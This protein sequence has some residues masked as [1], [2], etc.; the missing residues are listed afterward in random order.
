[1]KRF[2]LIMSV[3]LMAF[4]STAEAKED[5]KD[6]ITIVIN[7]TNIPDKP[8]R[9]P[10]RH[11]ISA[12]YDTLENAIYMESSMS[13]EVEVYITSNNEVLHYSPTINTVFYLPSNNGTYM[14]GLYSKSW[15]AYG[16]LEL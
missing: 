3:L 9:M 7:K 12:W 15:S 8:H 2:A 4:C 10:L 14:I 13:D 16:I 1:M 6:V 11:N 5:E